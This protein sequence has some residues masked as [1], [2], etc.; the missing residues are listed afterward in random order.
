MVNAMPKTA[1]KIP[2][3]IVCC[4]LNCKRGNLLF[5]VV[6]LLVFF[7][8]IGKPVYEAKVQKC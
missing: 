7:P 2:K 6:E 1:K 5:L 8:A 4:L 3:M